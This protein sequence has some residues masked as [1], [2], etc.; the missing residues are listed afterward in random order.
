MNTQKRSLLAALADWIAGLFLDILLREFVLYKTEMP[1]AGNR[2]FR[3]PLR[4]T[5]EI[6][7]LPRYTRRD[8]LSS[9]IPRA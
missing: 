5:T 4:C 6:R 8:N 7:P 3:S 1:S 9:A 2:G